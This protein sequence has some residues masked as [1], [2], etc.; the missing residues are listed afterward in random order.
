MQTAGG[1][2]SAYSRDAAPDVFHTHFAIA[3]LALARDP[4]VAAV[5]PVLCLPSK[6]CVDLD[7]VPAAV[8]TGFR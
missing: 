3:G 2:F 1:G 5:N 7:G 4:A 6:L 8:R